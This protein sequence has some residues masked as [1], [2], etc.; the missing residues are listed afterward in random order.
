MNLFAVIRKNETKFNGTFTLSFSVLLSSTH[1]MSSFQLISVYGRCVRDRL[2]HRR[3]RSELGRVTKFWRN[4]FTN[5]AWF[6]RTSRQNQRIRG[7]LNILI[8][9]IF[10]F[11]INEHVFSKLKF[12]VMENSFDRCRRD[13]KPLH[14]FRRAFFK[15]WDES[16][17]KS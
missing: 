7:D 3:H 17:P 9:S 8:V 13:F 10:S 16:V 2:K 1:S 14:P 11:H 5:F 4:C 15:I 6:P 12:R